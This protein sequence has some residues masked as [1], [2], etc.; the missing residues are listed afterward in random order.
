ML[1]GD[2]GEPVI[3]DLGHVGRLVGTPYPLHW[4]QA[5]RQ[6]LR[7]IFE[8]LDDAQ[9]QIDVGQCRNAAHAL[10]EIFGAGWRLKERV[11][12]ALREEMIESIDIAHAVFLTQ[13][14]LSS[15]AIG[16]FM[17]TSRRL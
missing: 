17:A 13:F 16:V 15:L 6:H 3:A 4:R 10:A 2:F 9:P 14:S 7:I 8:Q 1:G 12:I 5:V 11:V